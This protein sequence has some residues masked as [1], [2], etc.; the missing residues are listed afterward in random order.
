MEQRTKRK[1]IRVDQT[2]QTQTYKNIRKT[3]KRHSENQYLKLSRN[4]RSSSN[5]G[6]YYNNKI[7]G[8]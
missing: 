8:N 2:S 4:V 6:R 1:D 3:V 5:R 7:T